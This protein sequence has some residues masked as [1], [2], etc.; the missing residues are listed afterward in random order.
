MPVD[1]ICS[2]GTTDLQQWTCRTRCGDVVPRN[3][4]DRTSFF[5]LV[6]KM[7]TR[8]ADALAGSNT[9]NRAG[10]SGMASD[11]IDYNS[12]SA[13][14]MGR[15]AALMAGKNPPMSPIST[16]YAAPCTSSEG[17]TANANATWLN[18]CQFIVAV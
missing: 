17:V 8:R 14:T 12:R 7:G 13:V 6:A 2:V 1:T 5:R 4:R 18:D 9:G 10:A 3:W 15:R 16:A 11:E